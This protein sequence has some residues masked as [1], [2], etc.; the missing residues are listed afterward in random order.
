MS[1]YTFKTCVDACQQLETSCPN[2]EC[3]NWINFEQDLNC[4]KIAVAKNG[5]MTLREVSKRVGCSFVRVK[6][7][8]EEV[9]LKIKGQMEDSNYL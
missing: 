1:E 8:E 5:P 6:Q 9:L 3:R 7:I 4:V 2:E